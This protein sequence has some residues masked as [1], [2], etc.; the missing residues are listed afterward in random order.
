MPAITVWNVSTKKKRLHGK[1]NQRAMRKIA[2]RSVS[3]GNDKIEIY[4]GPLRNQ[5]CSLQV[6]L[7]ELPGEQVQPTFSFDIQIRK[8]WVGDIWRSWRQD[9]IFFPQAR[10]HLCKIISIWM[11][12]FQTTE[13][14]K[15]FCIL[16]SHG[17]HWKSWLIFIFTCQNWILKLLCISKM[18][19]PL[20]PPIYYDRINNYLQGVL[21]IRN[22]C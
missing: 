21:N 18:L 13:Y 4:D 19:I 12:S 5:L 15:S 17:K 20:A 11:L 14:T 1:A 22:D 7:Y 10:K 6:C 8:H 9:R 3:E 16:V 2:V